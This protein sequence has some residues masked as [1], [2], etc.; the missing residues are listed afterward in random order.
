MKLYGVDLESKIT[1]EMVRDALQECFYVAHCEDTSLGEA[2]EEE[3]RTYVSS[4][5]RSAFDKVKCDYEHPTKTGI[6]QVMGELQKFSASFRD[7]EII[8]KHA[9][10]MMTLVNK[11]ED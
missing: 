10:E 5:V 11:L 2:S 8:K 3:K 4:F 6:I 1:P 9:A 7:P